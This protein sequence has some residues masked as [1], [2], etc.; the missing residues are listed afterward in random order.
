MTRLRPLAVPA[1]AVVLATT[2]TPSAH[3]QSSRP[4]VQPAAW[5]LQSTV[6]VDAHLDPGSDVA[7]VPS[8]TSLP[9]VVLV[10]VIEPGA[11]GARYAAAP[12]PAG[13]VAAG[14]PLRAAARGPPA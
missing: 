14:P 3:A 12:I 11:R 8:A 13:A 9:P 7:T 6:P 2:G 5:G 10:D 4:V 1:A